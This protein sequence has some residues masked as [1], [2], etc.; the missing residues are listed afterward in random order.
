MR[1]IT[2]LF[3]DWRRGYTTVKGSA[4]GFLRLPAKFQHTGWV[5]FEALDTI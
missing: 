5:E 4:T 3:F 1:E 2:A